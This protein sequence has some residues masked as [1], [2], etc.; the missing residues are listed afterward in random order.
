MGLG[1]IF[2]GQVFNASDPVGD[3][4]TY[5]LEFNS[6]IGQVPAG[7]SID[8]K[9][10]DVTWVPND[11][12]VSTVPYAFNVTASDGNHPPVELSTWQFVT[13]VSQVTNQPPTITSA[14]NGGA[15]ANINYVYNATAVDPNGDP[16][17][18]LLIN[19]P[20]SATLDP[21]SGRFS[22]TPTQANVSTV[23]AHIVLR[24]YDPHGAYDEQTFDLPVHGTNS[25]PLIVSTP[26]TNGSSTG[27]YTYLVK[28][29]DP[30][31]DYVTLTAVITGGTVSAYTFHQIDGTSAM[32][33]WP[34]PANGAYNVV[35][36]ADDG[37]GGKYIQSFTLN[38]NN[39]V[40]DTPPVFIST[41]VTAVVGDGNHTYH[42]AAQA[43]DPNGSPAYSLI[44]LDPSG[45]PDTSLQ[46]AINSTTG[47]I[48]WVAPS[49][50][51]G[52]TLH[53]T[54][55]AK[56]N[57][58]SALQS[59]DLQVS[60]PAS[61]LPPTIDPAAGFI[62]AESTQFRTTIVAHD[63]EGRPLTY[64]LVADTA[65][66]ITVPVGMTIDNSGRI[67]W[68]APSVLGITNFEVQVTD[69]AGNTA[70][71]IFSITV[72]SHAAPTVGLVLSDTARRQERW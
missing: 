32:L 12:Q 51:A 27:G 63:P 18:W 13:V 45:V 71:Q 4:L 1:H 60:N 58:V 2:S 44:A 5:A 57:G 48:N 26:P 47:E 39:A 61:N 46:N 22:W 14:P 66:S 65:N 72:V 29:T 24:V 21:V 67:V 53:L 9:T 43:F 16:L 41:P 8:P 15:I 33:T 50:Y 56:Q 59:F 7:M 35:I 54:V 68:Q 19:A 31:G 69:D 34:A 49:R 42:Y 6:A 52:K 30:D 20:A 36:T 62:V 17:T 3:A 70:S 23:P 28:A 38:V 64:Q 37:K 25:P 11:S 40:V 10:G 55:I